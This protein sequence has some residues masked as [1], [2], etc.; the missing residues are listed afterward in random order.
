MWL[1]PIPSSIR[2]RRFGIFSFLEMIDEIKPSKSIDAIRIIVVIDS[3]IWSCLFYIVWIILFINVLIGV[4]IVIYLNEKINQNIMRKYDEVL[5]AVLDDIKPDKEEKE[6]VN[7]RIHSFLEK[8]NKGLKDAN[9]VLGG[10]GAKGTWLRGAHDADVFVQFNYEKYKGKSDELSDILEKHLNKKFDGVKRL[11]GSRDYFQIEKKGFVFEVVPVLKIAKAE[12]AVNI[13]DVSPL[14]AKWVRKH[15]KY[16]DDIR[17]MKKFCKA[18]RIYGAESYINGFSG[19]ICEILVIH[20]KGFVNLLRA[21]PK[22]KDEEIIDTEKHYRNRLEVKM[23]INKSKQQGPLLLVDPVQK[24]RNAAAALSKENYDMF[25]KSAHKF[26]KEPDKE[27]FEEKSIGVEELKENYHGKKVITVEASPLKGKKDVVGSKLVKVLEH[28]KRKMKK[29]GFE[30]I[31]TVWEWD[32]KA[33]FYIVLKDEKLREF[34]IKEGPPAK[35][36]KHADKF[37]KIYE[38]KT[39]VKDGKLY[40]KVKRKYRKAESFLRNVL[41]DGYVKERVKGIRIS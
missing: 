37:K 20:Y 29:A 10:S 11:H 39:F 22:W 36:K 34:E 4:C 38:G 15:K 21:A 41:R 23:G 32:G 25:R 13:T 3:S 7:K 12:K 17:L 16:A 9:A 26:L 18:H 27:S 1:R 2:R 14:H 30:I 31:D 24:N 35:I 28:I 19:Y 5:D 8:L 6:K 40:A 33:V